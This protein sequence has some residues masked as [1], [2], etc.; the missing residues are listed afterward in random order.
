MD[1]NIPPR[2]AHDPTP[3]PPPAAAPIPPAGARPSQIVQWLGTIAVLAIGAAL[4]LGFSSVDDCGSPWNPDYTAEQ[5]LTNATDAHDTCQD[6]Y[7]N[8]SPMAL[9]LLA[10]GAGSGIAAFTARHR[11]QLHQQPPAAPPT[12]PSETP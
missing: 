3:T 1:D 4:Y 11:E 12:G 9:V 2:P 8:R 7:G 6:A 5:T 10:I